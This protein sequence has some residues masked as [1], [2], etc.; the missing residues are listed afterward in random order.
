MPRLVFNLKT[1]PTAARAGYR[2]KIY[3]V[4]GA[5][6]QIFGYHYLVVL[7]SRL[8]TSPGRLRPA[9]LPA[10]ATST[11]GGGPQ[12][13]LPPRPAP[14]QPLGGEPLHGQSAAPASAFLPALDPGRQLPGRLRATICWRRAGEAGD[15]RPARERPAP[16]TATRVEQKADGMAGDGEPLRLNDRPIIFSLASS[17]GLAPVPAHLSPQRRVIQRRLLG[18]S[19]RVC[20]IVAAVEHGADQL[21][22]TISS[23]SSRPRRSPKVIAPSRGMGGRRGKAKSLN[24]KIAKWEKLARRNVSSWRTK[25]NSCRGAKKKEKKIRTAA[26]IMTIELFS[27]GK[28]ATEP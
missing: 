9:D 1:S 14:G 15:G 3:N 24:R 10:S 27:K 5:I 28:G 17:Q 4:A 18:L 26:R 6:F 23:Q 12:S 25:K 22:H 13:G 16:G 8:E 2:F 7:V 21:P 11:V 19:S 20:L